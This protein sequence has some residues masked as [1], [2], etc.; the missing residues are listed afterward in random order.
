[1]KNERTFN[2]AFEQT[3]VSLL[4]SS[5]IA[6]T[7]TSATGQQQNLFVTPTDVSSCGQY[8]AS[9]RES[10]TQSK[11]KSYWA[12]VWTWGFL[13]RYNLESPSSP[14]DIPTEVETIH[15]FIEKYCRQ[16]PLGH[17]IQSNYFI[18]KELGGNP[19]KSL[20]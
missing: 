13:S 8:M 5:A 19:A 3:L 15:L 10:D 6:L 17:L 20:P 7:C 18:I 4:V 2:I 14:I 11:I 9:R 1:M 16:N 12:V